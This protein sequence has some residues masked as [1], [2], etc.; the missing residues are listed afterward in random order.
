[1]DLQFDKSLQ[2]NTYIV[3]ASTNN[4]AQTDLD[5]FAKFGEPQVNVGGPIYDDENALVEGLPSRWLYIKSNFPLTVSFQNGTMVYVHYNGMPDPNP[6]INGPEPVAGTVTI[7]P[8]VDPERLANAW[9]NTLKSNMTK[10]LTQ[11]RAKADDFTGQD[12]ITI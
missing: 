5:L 11:L 1:M 7:P 3:T 12:Q 10:V 8:D 6:P 9:I 4:F 2:N